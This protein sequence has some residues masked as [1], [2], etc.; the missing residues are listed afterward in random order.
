MK[1]KEID[2]NIDFNDPE[3]GFNFEFKENDLVLTFHD[4]KNRLI[5]FKFVMVYHFKY[6]I[7]DSLYIGCP[8]AKLVE[9]E[10]SEIIEQLI[11]DLTLSDSEEVHHIIFSTNE[12]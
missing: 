8:C 1:F 3:T 6:L 10:D 5:E 7:S 11:L 2:S 9:V 4:W 12:A